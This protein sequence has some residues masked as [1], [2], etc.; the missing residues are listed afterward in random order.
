MLKSNLG[1]VLYLWER[2]VKYLRVERSLYGL[3]SP[4]IMGCWLASF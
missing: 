3:S 1:G 4:A 2:R